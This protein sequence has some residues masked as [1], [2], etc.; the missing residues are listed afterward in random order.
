M[1]DL[2]QRDLLDLGLN[3]ECEESETQ[4]RISTAKSATHAKQKS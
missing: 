3:R 1:F 2:I 4:G